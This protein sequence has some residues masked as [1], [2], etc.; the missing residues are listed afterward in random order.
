MKQLT[1]PT[2]H[3][4][5]CPSSDKTMFLLNENDDF[6]FFAHGCGC[7]RAVSK[8]STRAKSMREKYDRDIDYLRRVQRI[9]SSRPDYSFGGK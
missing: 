1:A 6:W 9:R 8:P 2:C 4:G 7:T 5:N 3:W